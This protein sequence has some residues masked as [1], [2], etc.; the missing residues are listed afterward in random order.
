MNNLRL[1]GKFIKVFLKSRAEYRFS[2]FISAF[3]QVITY[4]NIFLLMWVMLNRFDSIHGWRFHEIMFLYSLN[5]LSYALAG[6]F[7]KHPMLDMEQMIQM[8]DFDS[9]MT[10]PLDPFFHVVA[11]QFEYTFFGHIFLCIITFFCSISQ[12][13]IIWSAGKVIAFI[14]FVISG[15][16]IQASF[17][18]IAGS[19]CFFTVKSKSAVET[20]IYSMRSF[21]DYPISIFNKVFQVILTFI[22]P[23]TFVNYYPTVY[24]LGKTESPLCLYWIPYL[25]PLMGVLLISIAFALWNFGIKNYK[26]TGS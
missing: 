13:D 10:K 26:S 24:F 21:L 15:V 14:L 23:Y 19:I 1:Y 9:I 11:R 16:L 4:A 17:M 3:L 7:I 6:M 5:L 22:I 12:I 8:G 25:A 20:M 18:I 2:F